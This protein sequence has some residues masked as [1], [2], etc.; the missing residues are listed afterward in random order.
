MTVSLYA[1]LTSAS[2]SQTQSQSR[3]L[4]PPGVGGDSPPSPASAVD[5]PGSAL[6]PE[7]R[8]SLFA[9]V[10]ELQ[11]AGATSDEIKSFV[12]SELEANGVDFTAGQNRSGQLINIMS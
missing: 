1:D 8:D 6:P 10:G 7:T 3:P 5:N 2:L 11:E 9:A 12:D 4:P